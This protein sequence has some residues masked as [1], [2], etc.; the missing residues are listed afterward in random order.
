MSVGVGNLGLAGSNGLWSDRKCWEGDKSTFRP[1]AA[2]VT[3][4]L[5]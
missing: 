5:P 4:M 3:F 2:M 1:I